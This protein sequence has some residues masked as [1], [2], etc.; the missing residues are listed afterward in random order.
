MKY[1]KNSFER[2]ST[3]FLIIIYV[4]IILVLCKNSYHFLTTHLIKP[5][6]VNVRRRRS[7]SQ[8][9]AT[10]SA[11][12]GLR[13]LSTWGGSWN[14]LATTGRQ[15]FGTSVRPAGSGTGWERC[16]GGRGRSHECPPC[17]IKRW[18]SQSYFLGQR[19]GF[20]QRRCPGS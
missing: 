9:N 15:Y 2:L 6:S 19:P 13:P 10:R 16:Y 17:F 3:F 12:M 14:G 18:S 11:Y 8:E 4:Y 7:A 20:C 5:N 1:I